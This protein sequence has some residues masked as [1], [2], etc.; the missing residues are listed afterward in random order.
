MR[1]N[2]HLSDIF[3]VPVVSLSAFFFS[4]RGLPL[5]KS[6]DN[7]CIENCG[8]VSIGETN[9]RGERKLT[10]TILCTVFLKH[11]LILVVRQS[12]EQVSKLR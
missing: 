12:T 4:H 2:T 5:G 6:K 9:T 1:P 10:G 8:F 7:R 11:T 3:V